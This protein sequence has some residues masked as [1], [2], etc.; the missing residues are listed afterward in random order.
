MAKTEKRDP[1]LEP[2][3]REAREWIRKLDRFRY[4]G[5]TLDSN[6]VEDLS[7]LLRRMEAEL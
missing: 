5:I 7:G 6:E 3:R 2:V 4:M 1:E